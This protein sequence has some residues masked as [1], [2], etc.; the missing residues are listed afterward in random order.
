MATQ[1]INQADLDAAFKNY[2]TTITSESFNFGD[3]ISPEAT[4]LNQSPAPSKPEKNEEKQPKKRRSWGQQLPTPTTNLPPR[5]DSLRACSKILTLTIHRKRAKTEAEKEQRRIERVIRNRL[6][7]HSSRER[8]RKEVEYL[9]DEKSTIESENQRLKQQLAILASKNRELQEENISLKAELG[10]PS[11]GQSIKQEPEAYHSI[12]SP[13]SSNA[14]YIVGPRDS[15]SPPPMSPAT[16]IHDLAASSD[17]AQ[18][19]AEML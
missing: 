19:P 7:A 9:E 13:P 15:I 5:Y 10:R 1:F 4:S 16:E 12:P 6:A 2:S 11:K 8:K 14:S 3:T 18:H 17:M